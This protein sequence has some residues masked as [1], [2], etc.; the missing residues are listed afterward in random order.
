MSPRYRNSSVAQVP[1][2]DRLRPWHW[3]V[4]HISHLYD[5]GIAASSDHH[6]LVV[7]DLPPHNHTYPRKDQQQP[8]ASE[9]HYLVQMWVLRLNLLGS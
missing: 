3:T 8:R 5:E 4:Q 7:A 9:R 6:A 2:L 1:E